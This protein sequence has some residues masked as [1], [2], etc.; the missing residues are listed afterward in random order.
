MPPKPKSPAKG[1]GKG[2]LSK[3]EKERLKKE[4]EAQKLKEEEEEKARKE[5]EEKERLERERLEREE[6]ERILAAEHQRHA[7]QLAELASI[8]EGNYTALANLDNARRSKAKW[9][10]YMRC[11]GSP[12]PTIPAEINTYINLWKD[13]VERNSID[14]V[15]KESKLVLALIHELEFLIEDT[16]DDQLDEMTEL[17][18]EDTIVELQNVLMAKTDQAT[19]LLLKD[20]SSKAD[21]ETG[22]LQ[23]V[24]GSEDLVLMLWGNLVKNP[25]FKSYT[26]EEQEL[27]FELPKQLALSDIGVRVVHTSYDHLSHRCRTFKLKRPRFRPPPPEEELPEEEAP[28]P[29]EG[30]GEKAEGEEGEGDEAEKGETDDADKGEK[31]DA[32]ESVPPTPKEPEKAKAPAEETGEE[33]EEEEEE[34]EEEG[35]EYELEDEDTV[36]LRAYQVL[37]GVIHLDLLSLPPQPKQVKSWLMTQETPNELKRVPYGNTDGVK[38]GA[39]LSGTLTMGQTMDPKAAASAAAAA[40][41]LGAPPVGVTLKLPENVLFSEEPQMVYWWDEG[42]QWRLDGFVDI[43]FDQEN[44]TLSFKTIKFGPLACIQDKHINMPFQS[45]EL[46]PLGVNHTRLTIIAAILEVEIEI[47]DHLCC[48]RQTGENEPKPELASITEKWLEP[49]VLIETMK[50][51][52]VNLFPEIDSK[53]YVS[54]SEKDEQT[55][56]AAYDQ[57]ALSASYFA[58]SWSKWNAETPPDKVIMLGAEKLVVEPVKDEDW[59]VILTSKAQ[60][61]KLKMGEYDEEF[62]EAHAEGTQFHADLYHMVCDLSTE[63]GMERMRNTSFRFVDAVHTM[64]E[65]TRIIAYS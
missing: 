45:W 63:A 16:P 50:A 42:K 48:F 62:S 20:A 65:A 60:T 46:Y 7:A 37:G 9:E 33:G 34:E 41:A 4:E 40:E 43:K 24:A 28:P 14:C 26:F 15:L 55:E 6:R 11:D 35:E 58:Y 13:D 8:L 39:S 49:K 22:N 52:G 36:D 57:M 10:R 44:R 3:A 59:A 51:A 31:A 29:V 18:Y 21:S 30:E 1:K 64:L 38:L 32:D 23:F 27:T 2:K 53:K 47:K 56:A 61:C 5:L 19:V 54:V 12:D 17:R 25:R